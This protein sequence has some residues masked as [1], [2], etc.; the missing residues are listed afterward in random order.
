MSGSNAAAIIGGDS[1]DPLSNA[2]VSIAARSN[3]GGVD[4][5]P[6]S[7]RQQELLLKEEAVTYEASRDI[8]RNRISIT[9]EEFRNLR[10]GRDSNLER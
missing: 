6:R 8:T 7:E 9:S 5:A 2:A 3:G 10:L 4:T 1:S